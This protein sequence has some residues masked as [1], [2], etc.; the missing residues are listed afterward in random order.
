MII[1]D[2]KRGRKTLMNKETVKK[3]KENFALF[4]EELRKPFEASNPSDPFLQILFTPSLGDCARIEAIYEIL[5]DELFKRTGVRKTEE[6][7]RDVTKK[8]LCHPVWKKRMESLE[9]SLGAG[10]YL[11]DCLWLVYE[12]YI[13][14][15][16]FEKRAEIRR[17]FDWADEMRRSGRRK[18]IVSAP[19]GLGK[20]YQLAETIAR[21]PYSAVIFMPNKELR[22]EMFDRIDG[23][24]PGEV[25]KIEGREETNCAKFRQ[26]NS[27]K[28]R[29]RENKAAICEQCGRAD[30]GACVTKDQ[31]DKSVRYRLLVTTHAQY[32]AFYRADFLSKWSG[33]IGKDLPCKECKTRDFFIIDE[34]IVGMHFFEC[35]E[36]TYKEFAEYRR[37]LDD[38]KERKGAGYFPSGF[39]EK[40]KRLDSALLNA[41]GE[42]ALILPVDP[43]FALS[44][45]ERRGFGSICGKALSE[46]RLSK[47]MTK[48]VERAIQSGCSFSSYKSIDVIYFNSATTYPLGEGSPFHIFFDATRIQNDLFK[49]V[50]PE[51]AQ[52]EI[53]RLSIPVEPLGTLTIYHTNN[54]DVPKTSKLDE[55]IKL[56]LRHIVAHYNVRKPRYFIVTTGSKKKPQE[57]YRGLVRDFFEDT[58]IKIIDEADEE[59]KEKTDLSKEERILK[60]HHYAVINN[61]GNLRGSNRAKYCDVG[62]LIGKFKVPDAVEVAW[63]IPYIQD[64]MNSEVVSETDRKKGFIPIRENEHHPGIGMAR[65]ITNDEEVQECL[66][67][68]EFAFVGNVSRWRRDTENEQAIGRT[69][70]LYH[71]VTFYAVTKDLMEDYGFFEYPEKASVIY[72]EDGKAIFGDREGSYRFFVKKALDRLLDM[73]HPA[74]LGKRQAQFKNEDVLAE[75]KTVMIKLGLKRKLPEPR[76]VSD[77]IKTYLASFYETSHIDRYG[78]YTIPLSARKFP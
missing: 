36:V 59:E 2:R 58:D 5:S 3:I 17:C 44:T 23:I 37:L 28:Q 78:T 74:N 33:T 39:P 19:M 1:F 24:V 57:G 13:D 64:A 53:P 56:Y 47:H 73:D 65:V 41:S 67:K 18:G 72:D 12:L 61:F 76:T 54:S 9:K 49:K 50:F 35:V 30:T 26:I 77:H 15:Y 48:F 34:D 69:R 8:I 14:I 46:R 38:T 66:Y 16:L 63:A 27:E 21:S 10:G 70:F 55:K 4:E 62:I 25:L 7:F 22:D 6:Y 68:P 51:R 20:T 31:K 43:E 71:D 42:S 40:V 11:E 45:D 52:G 60:G 29:F 75:I 32:E